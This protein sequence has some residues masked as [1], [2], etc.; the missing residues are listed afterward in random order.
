V[1]KPLAQV[2]HRNELTPQ[3]D[4]TLKEVWRSGNP[5]DVLHM[6][7]FSDSAD[8]YPVGFGVQVK[9]YYLPFCLCSIY[10]PGIAVFAILIR[11]A[12]SIVNR[13]LKHANF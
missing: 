10:S 5:G 3:V 4:D 13:F 7:D 8:V 6:D 12:W 1:T 9:D 2:Y 11:S